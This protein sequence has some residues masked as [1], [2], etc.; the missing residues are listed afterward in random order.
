MISRFRSVAECGWTG[1]DVPPDPG[2]GLADY[3]PQW[4]D[5]LAD[6]VTLEG[7]MMDGFV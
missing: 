2:N 7:S 6:G 1:P 5:H 3:Y 4:L